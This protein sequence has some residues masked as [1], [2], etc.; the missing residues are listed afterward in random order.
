MVQMGYVDLSDRDA[1][2]DPKKDPLIE[3]DA[4]VL[5]QESYP[6]LE[7]VWRM[8]DA[9]SKSW[10]GRMPTDAVLMFKTLIL[11]ALYNLSDDQIRD[12]LCSGIVA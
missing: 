11:S 12:R 5:W 1:R 3:I 8:P 9:D 6:T 2:L 7:R 10:A 4:V